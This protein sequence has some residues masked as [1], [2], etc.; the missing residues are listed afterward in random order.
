MNN[1]NISK[2][3]LSK[4]G[5]MMILATAGAI[6]IAISMPSDASADGGFTGTGQG[7]EADPYIIT[8]AD[9]LNE[10]RYNLSADYK[11]GNDI[12][13][14]GYSTG[15]GW[16]PITNFT[17]TFDG[18]GYKIKNLTIN[19]PST[20]Y[21]GLFKSIDFSNVKNVYLEN[22]NVKGLNNVGGL[23]GRLSRQVSHCVVSGT[24]DGLLRVGGLV[25]MINNSYGKIT[26]S[27][28]AANVSGNGSGGIAGV[29]IGTIENSYAIG[30]VSGAQDTG[31]IVGSNS[32]SGQVQNSYYDQTTTG[33]SD[34]GKGVPKTTAEMKQEATYVGWDFDTD[35]IINEGNGYPELRIFNSDQLPVASN[36]ELT[37]DSTV[38]STLTATYD[39]QDADGDT[40]AGTTFAF[41]SY[42]ADGTSNETEVQAASAAN[43]Y[44]IQAADVGKVIKVKVVPINSKAT[45]NEAVSDAT[46][47]ITAQQEF[48]GGDGTEA[49]PYQIATADQLNNV[50]NHL[51]KHFVLLN[52]IDLS[53]Y[54]NWDPIG[55][56][57][58]K[59][60]GTF[61]GAGFEISNLTID[62]MF[63]HA[64]LFE[65]ADHSSTLEN[66]ILTDVNIKQT[67]FFVAAGSLVGFHEGT[68]RN[69]SVS[70]EIVGMS[71]VG[72]LV[73][74]S[75]GG[76]ISNSFSTA[77]V[78]GF[79]NL[80]GLVG[81]SNNSEIED[82]H[83]TGS[84]TGLL[85]VG[86]L[87]GQS[88]DSKIIDSHATGTIT[89]G[90]QDVGGLVGSSAYSEIVNS[91]A[92]GT[93]T[94][95]NEEVGGL[96]GSSTSS[97]ITNSYATGTVTSNLNLVGGL[98]GSS[99]N[100]TI[101]NSYA[102]GT[103]TG[104]MDVGGLVGRS[105][106]SEIEVSYATGAITADNGNVGG[107]VGFSVNSKIK[108]S[109]ATGSATGNLDVGGLVG[110][111]DLSEIKDSYATGSATGN[112]NVVGG[113]V[114]MNTN[115]SII[116]DS[117]AMGLVTTNG[118]SKGGLVGQNLGQVANSYYDSETTG[119]SDTGKGEP[120][121]TAEMK[122]QAT[123]YGWD[124]TNTWAIQVGTH[125]PTLRVFNS[126]SDQPPIASN[127]ALTGTAKV[128]STL[129]A[130]YD[131]TDTDG[132]TEAGTTY[133]F[134]SYGADGL[135]NEI[136]VQAASATNTY[137]IQAADVGKV[138]KVKVVPKNTN[139]TGV[140]VGS[141]A[142][143]VITQAVESADITFGSAI[144]YTGQEIDVP[145]SISNITSDIGSIGLKFKYDEEALEVVSVTI[146]PS[147]EGYFDSYFN[148]A[149][150]DL[151]VAWVDMT[152]GD[153]P[154]TGSQQQDLFIVKFRVK[155]DATAGDKVIEIS[156]T[157]DAISLTDSLADNVIGNVTSGKITVKLAPTLTY[158]N[159]IFTESNIDDGSI[160]NTTP[161]TITLANDTFVGTDGEDFIAL[162]RLR[163]QNLPEGLT[164]QAVRTTDTQL[165]VT[166]AGNASKHLDYNDVT[167][168][169]FTFAS[170]AF[171][172]GDATKV[173]NA[174]KDDLMIDFNGTASLTYSDTIF[175][176]AATNDGSINT[177]P[178]TITLA[179]DE[180]NG[181]TNEDFVTSGKLNVLNVPVGLIPVATLINETQIELKLTGNAAKH[182]NGNDV[183]NIAI[184]FLDTAFTNAPASE[185]EFATK[186]GISIEYVNNQPSITIDSHEDQFVNADGQATLSGTAT[187]PNAGQSLPG[188]DSLT[189]SAI[190]GGLPKTAQVDANGNWILEWG[191]SDLAEGI[192]TPITIVVDDGSS[193]ANSQASV[194]YNGRII[195]DKVAPRIE[196]IEKSVTQAT[197]QY[198]AIAVQATDDLSGIAE[199][200]FALGTDVDYAQATTFDGL[201]FNVDQNGIY[202]VWVRDKANNV[203]FDTIEVTEI[204]KQGP[205]ISITQ[206]TTQPTNQNVTVT[207][208]TIEPVIEKKWAI[209]IQSTAYF[210]ASGSSYTTG[211][212]V[213]VEENGIYTV[214]VKDSAGNEV[215]KSIEITNIDKT[216][217]VVQL[218]VAENDPVL[219]RATISVQIAETGS[220]IAVSKWVKGLYT[221]DQFA[222]NDSLG[223]DI[224]GALFTVEENDTYTVYVKDNAGN[225][226]IDTITVGNIDKLAIVKAA[227]EIGYATGDSINAVTQSVT[228]PTTGADGITITWASDATNVIGT[229]G[230]VTRPANSAG[231]ASVTL[232]AII[233]DGSATATKV[234]VV[235]VLKQAQTE[236]EA[237]ANAKIAL[238]IGYA[239][240]DSLNAVTQNVTFVSAGTDGAM[241]TWNSDTPSV[242][243]NDGTVTRPA[244]S[245]GDASVTLT[246]T[247][248]KGGVTDT[249]VFVVKVLKQAQTDAEAV[250]NAKAALEIGY[251]I[252][253]SINS[254][255]QSVSLPT[256]GADGATITW[257]SDTPNVIGT[258]GTVTRPVNSAGDASVTLTATITKGG[259]TE[260][261]VFVVKVLRQAQTDAEAVANA[262]IAL[263]IG[264]ATGDSLNAVTQNVTFISAG[265]DGAMITWNSDTPSVIANDG[266]VTRPANSAGDAS[267]TLTATIIK[268][269][270]TETK[271]FVVKVL[272][273]AQTDAE[274]VAN[275]KAALEIGYAT[276]DSLNAVTQNVTFISAGADGAMITWNSDTP[277]VIANDG[278]VT[279]PANSAGDAS[280]TLTATI[281]KGGAIETKVFVVKVLKQTQ[282][283]AEAVASAKAALEIGHAIGDSINSVTQSVSLPTMGADGATITWTSDTTNVIGTDGTVT[284]PANSAGD[285]SVTLTATI[286]KGGATETKIFVVKVLKQAQTDAEAV[287]NAKAALEIGY[288]TG[289]SVNAVTQNVTFTSAGA[290]G[291]MIAWNSDTPSVIANDGTVTRPVNSTG[292]ASVTLTATITKGGAIETKVFV[293]KVLKQSQTDAE[294]VANAKAA[295]EIG[296]AT[297]D[298]LNA[299][300]QN[301]TFTSAG[302]DGA[303]ITWNSDTP[304]VIANDG[305]VTRPANSAGDASVTLTATITKGGATE[306]KVYVVKVLK[307]VQTDAEAVTNAKAALEIGYATGDSLNAVTQNVIFTSAGADG[308]MITWNS[309]TPSVIANDGTVTRPANSA[310][311]A[312]VTLTATITKGG[313][314]E[315]K[316]FVVKVLKQTQTEAEAVTNAKAALE[317][318][319]A[320]GD[321]LNAVTQNVTF[322]SAGADGAMITWNSDTPSVIA[323]DGTVTRPANSAGDAS[324]TLTA[325]ITKGGATETKVFVVKV[326]KQAQTDVEAVANAK[327]T[328]EIGYGAGDSINSVTQSVTLPIMGADGA[329]IT[330]NSDTPSV[331]ANDGTV[332]RPANS[333]G[334]ASV[335]LTATITKGTETTSKVFVVKVLKQSQTDA[336]AVANAKA[337]LEIGYGTGDSINAVT[338]S[339]TLPTTGA[340]DT[341]ITWASDATNVIGQDGT[342]TRPTNGAGDVSVTL[343][344]TITKGGVSTTKVFVLKVLKLHDID[345]PQISYTPPTTWTNR[346]LLVT[347]IITD[348]GSG[349]ASTKWAV[350]ENDVNYFLSNGTSF[351]NSFEVAMNGT[352][353]VYAQDV[354]GNQSVYT[355]T[356]GNIDTTLPT[357]DVSV[358]NTATNDKVPI[359]VDGFDQDSGV[360]I[361]KW[362]EGTRTAGD[363]KDVGSLVV[364]GSFAVTENGNYTVY[365]RD[366]AGNEV[367]ETVEVSSIDNELPVILVDVPT[368]W[369]TGDVTISATV[370]EKGGSIA[371]TR[372]A[373]G[374]QDAN[375]FSDGSGYELTPFGVDSTFTRQI[376]ETTV[377]EWNPEETSQQ[378]SIVDVA[379]DALS[380]GAPET[381]TDG[382]LEEG[383]A[384]ETP[385]DEQ[386]EEGAPETPT[387]EQSEGGAPETPTDEQSEEK[388]PEETPADEQIG[389]ENAPQAPEAVIEPVLEMEIPELVPMLRT[390][391][392]D[393]IELNYQFTVS[394]NNTYTIYTKDD[395]G[396]E[397]IAHV[398]VG[399]IDNTAPVVTATVVDHDAI[400]FEST[401]AVDI[402]ENQSGIKE[403]KWAKGT[404][405]PSDFATLGT[406]L[407]GPTFNVN[408]NGTYTVYVKDNAGN[409]SVGYVTVETITLPSIQI[410]LLP[411]STNDGTKVS[412]TIG[413]TSSQ[414]VEKKWL[415]GNKTK[416]DFINAGNGFT[417]ND[418][419]IS[420]EGIYT[421]YIKDASGNEVIKTF[422]YQ[423]KPYQ[424]EG[425]LSNSGG[426]KA[427]ATISL[428]DDTN[429]TSGTKY[430][431]F[432]LMKGTTPVSVVAVEKTLQATENVSA[433]FNVTGSGYTVIVNVLDKDITNQT[434]VG[435]SLADS[436]TLTIQN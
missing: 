371:T 355:F 324:V 28:S 192:Y 214:Y 173:A 330:W 268:G 124:F 138:I 249:K 169:T 296:Y 142:T 172:S 61:D 315:T 180:F 409:E 194:T 101:T 275:A 150:G 288:A 343:T 127:V 229:D 120:K 354:A 178:I 154:I 422:V 239:T 187:D 93:V 369:T 76:V 336:E 40:E 147:L 242:I 247:I 45:G 48:A 233:T 270:A 267:V 311:D 298:S 426:L 413:N 44:V 335:T 362:L 201:L 370:R 90:Q 9:H 429:P 385:T 215:T 381:P 210:T 196:K 276:G 309:D 189:V 378:D 132:D 26:T 162:D 202:K 59:F 216:A 186:D 57:F 3:P 66:I 411:L 105:D 195:V 339:V 310:G 238:E 304:S 227:L 19:R 415:K 259:A 287:A 435:R 391:T 41:Y 312:S 212:S 99:T 382:Q 121:T 252:G 321:S 39:Y 433:Y 364:D 235:K 402:D 290:D 91:Y 24:V 251:A 104:S 319:Y 200:K 21:V 353:T 54:A 291:A 146:N 386:S 166:I 248:I 368:E 73:G 161:V 153:Q 42:D 67:A 122:Q 399:N 383:A 217:P 113:L 117:Y 145:V 373:V 102:T 283:E 151:N 318:G 88:N 98:A 361:I 95:A 419:T 123:Y 293:V 271:V 329:T 38:G 135:S 50:R 331:I 107:L 156:T 188:N 152:G 7:T 241:I 363:F 408:E 299:V 341:T 159:T 263:E 376:A 289:D 49:S 245:A 47:V 220:G 231:D 230:T 205:E 328:L 365:I 246:A 226:T 219:N 134:Y 125:Y 14:S 137:V 260:T 316:V 228:L 163:V 240:G 223:V 356:V 112:D 359:V 269:G 10:V 167:N 204:D 379:D 52:D 281:I 340:D 87:V 333:A 70:G 305:T 265:V 412:V 418:F 213:V 222:T 397:Q 387:D 25:G 243:A 430:V 367:V 350:D 20:S 225:T 384:P 94:S 393:V 410:E 221:I 358:D 325:T 80:G 81:R 148:N 15:A 237:V 404:L 111:S 374:E 198:V 327:A 400:N 317:I 392:S 69:S 234:F 301:V 86:G 181:T 394:E 4:K 389:E 306:T 206:T 168:L 274:A 323:N 149:T 171:T 128:G 277:S 27:Y 257:T 182:G 332:T 85:S 11:L 64:G 43:T 395:A 74:I 266:T 92:T 403:K 130:A 126:N 115:S 390:M 157:A 155:S 352:Y 185:V 279:R 436:R 261:K 203:T 53:G 78:D 29:N 114:G 406:E 174:T 334:D 280:V 96:V 100:S 209:G 133:A 347:P 22:V 302:A 427:T 250:A 84:A 348:S 193:S 292:D 1:K 244:N 322:T 75:D 131:Y 37:G 103:V 425:S 424:I 236:A 303:M 273:Q 284:R 255:T 313:A 345:A 18:A 51:D 396:N 232:T 109:Y 12:N 184:E 136:E 106:G 170:G 286:T 211:D 208:N 377:G 63:R 224:E 308:A 431:V 55:D 72:G 351:S 256:M 32:S 423:T 197:N 372:W 177:T 34:T 65:Y 6:P 56:S 360:E 432:Q 33:Q 17:G 405:L 314:I 62:T 5:L 307:Q 176:E 344:A 349:I 2:F 179:L 71:D 144:A 175:V 297:G 58:A 428:Q 190:M 164:A 110:M 300:T 254:V 77:S 68:I 326:L 388:A 346:P 160:N 116:E 139:G 129:T 278:T 30:S 89:G 35:W 36:V 421:V 13:L 295:L 108:D 264:Y 262:K 158:T 414:I 342:V 191:G 285:A 141:Q 320:T 380:G 416:F 8:T 199:K 272:K 23:A 417:G 420:E 434:D 407:A 97:T 82:S 165:S 282:T 207:A 294:A 16:E 258:D 60:N 183:S 218:A 253:D 31:G 119:Q 338:Q 375:Y 83:A 401:I 79:G 118:T 46:D 337:A 366:V 143:A 398:T 357:L 140:E